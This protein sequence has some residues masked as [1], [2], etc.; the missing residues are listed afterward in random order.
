MREKM[1]ERTR[2]LGATHSQ[3][4]DRLKEKLEEKALQNYEKVLDDIR[5]S[6]KTL[7]KGCP[8]TNSLNQT[9]RASLSVRGLNA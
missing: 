4:I 5:D 2:D 9:S 8:S 3:A 7:E 1:T 6:L